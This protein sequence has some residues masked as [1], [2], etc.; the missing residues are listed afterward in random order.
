MDF[1]F[2]FNW[3]DYLISFVLGI[4][5]LLGFLKG[6]FKEAKSIATLTLS[7][8]FAWAFRDYSESFLNIL[9][10]V[11]NLNDIFSFLLMFLPIYLVIS[12]LIKLF[13]KGINFFNSGFLD[14]FLGSLI[15]F[16]KGGLIIIIVFLLSNEY[17]IYQSWW[18]KSYLSEQILFLADLIKSSVDLISY[19]EIKDIKIN[20]NFL[21]DNL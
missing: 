2:Y 17:I 14:K 15:G 21:E 3:F 18:E 13:F 16:L 8:F 9:I 7:V 10:K 1:L 20:K 4:Y 11:E 12:L 19:E 5:L 6:L